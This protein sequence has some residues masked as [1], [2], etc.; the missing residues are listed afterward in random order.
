MAS[1]KLHTKTNDKTTTISTTNTDT[2][3][4]LKLPNQNGTLATI[5]DIKND[6]TSYLQENTTWTVGPSEPYK[7]LNEALTEASKLY[8]LYLKTGTPILTIK[9]KSGVQFTEPLR[10]NNQNLSFIEITSEDEWVTVAETAAVAVNS[11][12]EMG[13]PTKDIKAVISVINRGQGPILNCKLRYSSNSNAVF[14]YLIQ[15]GSTGKVGRKGGFDTFNTGLYITD[16]SIGYWEGVTFKNCLFGVRMDNV[17]MG[18]GWLCNFTNCQISVSVEEMAKLDMH[19]CNHTAG[20]LTQN[21]LKAGFGS[22]VWCAGQTINNFTSAHTLYMMGGAIGS[23]INAGAS[24]STSSGYKGTD[25]TP[26]VWGANG[27]IRGVTNV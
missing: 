16:A 10:I 5:D 15:G 14:G 1:I 18:F 21:I 26:N 7:T 20:V 19:I 13:Q 11:T 27:F 9:L 3:V 2:H 6:T 25:I 4:E 23:I 22:T 12:L 8:P 17:S 24:G